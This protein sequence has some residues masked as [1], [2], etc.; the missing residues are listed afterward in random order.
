MENNDAVERNQVVLP[1]GIN[2]EQYCDSRIAS[3]STVTTSMNDDDTN[4]YN[5]GTDDYDT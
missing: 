1:F 4:S 2:F 3:S 5:S